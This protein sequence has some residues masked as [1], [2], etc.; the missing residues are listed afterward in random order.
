MFRVNYR[1]K[2][3][4]VFLTKK[5]LILIRTFRGR[6]LFAVYVIACAK[7]WVPAFNNNLL[8]HLPIV[9]LQLYRSYDVIIK[10]YFAIILVRFNCQD[11]LKSF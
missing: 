6:F 4:G 3:L 2:K 11:I 7:K 1:L 5:T 8:K 9:L 10:A